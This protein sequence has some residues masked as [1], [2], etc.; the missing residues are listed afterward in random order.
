MFG[1]TE[2][3]LIGKSFFPLIHED[4]V[5]VTRHE[6]KKLYHAPFTCIIEQRA[7]TNTGWRW[8]S[9]C[10][11][12]ELNKNNEV[13]S[14]IGVGRDITEHKNAEEALR[15][16]QKIKSIGLLSSGIAHDYNNL[17]NIMI[18]NILLATKKISA[19][20]Q[21]VKFLERSLSAMKSAAT[22]T[23]QI[24]AYSGKG[25][26]LVQTID[27]VA[28][29]QDHLTLAKAS[30]PKNVSL[31]TNL[32]PTQ[33]YVK[34]DPAQIEQIVMNLI[35]NSGEA[36]GENQGVVSIEVSTVSFTN[37]ELT[38][39][40]V[41][42][43]TT[44]EQQEYASLRVSDNGNGMNKETMEKIFDPFFTTKFVGRG[45]GLSAVLGIIRGHKGGITIESKEGAGTAVCVLLPIVR[46]PV[47]TIEPLSEKQNPIQASGK[48]VLLIDDEREIIE[49][50]N[51]VLES[52][53]YNRQSTIDPV[54]GVAL[55]KE[56]WRNI[57]VVILDYSMPKMNGKEVLI[58]L[59]KINSNVKVIIS[60][61][62][63]EEEISDLMG[64]FK[65][66]SI[67]QKPYTPNALLSL[68]STVLAMK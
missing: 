66:T 44:L 5:E 41:L 46:V 12:S 20:H 27:M 32:S 62:Y 15:N 34:G 64:N 9:W 19:D 23:K 53:N 6:M 3:E 51:N 48:T 33:V 30:I 68:L 47:N 21:A 50:L 57:D 11:T 36:I 67:I 7:M 25:R 40:G 24:L 35:I 42:T 52:G 61:G 26:F 59:Q 29:V 4:D 43:N 39:F 45:L 8:F 55:Y 28:M 63:S 16:T 37:D 17:L 10:D 1:K 54:I 65:P 38:A 60:T 31:Q 49:M 56:H 58:E 18:G 14:I 2:A 22:L 13:I